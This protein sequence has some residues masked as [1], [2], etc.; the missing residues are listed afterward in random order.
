MV[1]YVD[2]N[3]N[4]DDY[5]AVP[6]EVAVKGYSGNAVVFDHESY[7]S[8]LG[9][10]WRDG[11]AM[12]DD[13]RGGVPNHANAC[14]KALT[15]AP[16]DDVIEEFMEYKTIMGLVPTEF[17]TPYGSLNT[18]N[19]PQV[20][21]VTLTAQG[22]SGNE[23]VRVFFLEKSRTYEPV[24]VTNGD[25]NSKYAKGLSGSSV[26][27][28]V[29]VYEAGY[30]PDSFS[31]ENG[32]NY[33]TYG[34]FFMTADADGK[35]EVDVDALRYEDGKAGKIPQGYYS[36]FIVPDDLDASE[37]GIYQFNATS[38]SNSG[39]TTP[40]TPD[41]PS[42]TPDNSDTPSESN[43]SNS[44]GGGGGSNTGILCASALVLVFLTRKH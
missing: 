39:N 41:T 8:D 24:T 6:I 28:L 19:I 1:R 11:T 10:E 33:A 27:S 32:V 44:G 12:V 3:D 17:N 7:F 13:F 4:D 30:P 23:R 35:L 34:P 36:V 43:T 2:L 20:S 29:P 21:K 42:I 31:V 15:I 40:S 14:I 18:D 26:W 16:N 25:A 9:E 38:G 22:V 5:A 37:F